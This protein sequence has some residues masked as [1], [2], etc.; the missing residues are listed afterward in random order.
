MATQLQQHPLA[1]GSAVNISRNGNHQYWIDDGPKAKSVTTMLKHIEGDTFG[2][3]LN[4]GIKMIRENNGDLDAP[5]RMNASSIEVGN[6][7]HATVDAY[8]QNGTIDEEDP[9]FLAWFNAIGESTDWLAS[10]RFLYHPAL[11]YGGTLDSVSMNADGE[12][13]LHDLK[14]VEP[15]SW[16]KYGSGLRIN[17]DSAQLAAYADA[18]TAMGSIWSPVSRGYITY[19]LR[20]GSGAEVV[21]VDLERG[22]KLFLASQALYLLT[23]SDTA[24]RDNDS[25]N[26]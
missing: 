7:L 15:L 25:G 1:D 24:R 14:T 16:A 18:L 4:W 21:E 3:G 10:E 13:L 2:V 26:S 20:D 11:Q 12:V 22:S 9:L 23:R 19:V 8:I 5:R 17:K 6:H